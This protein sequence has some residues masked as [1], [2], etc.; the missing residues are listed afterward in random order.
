M[1]EYE[2]YSV[3]ANAPYLLHEGHSIEDVEK[4]ILDY[5]L[6]GKIDPDLTD[7]LS[8]TIVKD[9]KVIHSVRGTDPKTFKD[10][11][12]DMGIALKHPLVQ[13]SINT[14]IA[15][16]G[17]DFNN[18]RIPIQQNIAE[19]V[20][21]LTPEFYQA[22]MY[23]IIGEQE[24]MTN[25]AEDPEDVMPEWSMEE[26]LE[27]V[28][29][30]ESKIKKAKNLQKKEELSNIAYTL[31][32][33]TGL[34]GLSA[35]LNNYKEKNRIAPEI[36]KLEKIKQKYPNRKIELTGHSLGSVVNVL[37]RKEGLKTI[38]FNP[39]PQIDKGQH[40]PNSKIYRTKYDPVSF[41]LSG[42][43][44]EPVIEINKKQ[45]KYSHSLTNFLPSKSNPLPQ[46]E[47]KEK[48]TKEDEIE[49]CRK[50]P[51]DPNCKIFRT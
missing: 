45:G 40:H 20:T 12:S 5:G 43:D 4:E 8:T 7:D 36:E 29:R 34:V 13:K 32:K 37:G 24:Y 11:I 19:E 22:Q 10:L 16:G 42:A 14:L 2:E 25:V 28:S 50:F 23:N 49:Y 35:L 48:Y 44:T 27:E 51:N 1:E 3:Y 26:W 15:I 18:F 38:T 21:K 41:F 30:I 6:T 17:I 46:I 39:A 33:G 47:L 31:L 9:D